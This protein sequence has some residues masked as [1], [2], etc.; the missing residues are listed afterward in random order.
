[1]FEQG[2]TKHCRLAMARNRHRGALA[3]SLVAWH[4]AVTSSPWPGQGTAPLGVVVSAQTCEVTVETDLGLLVRDAHA[5]SLASIAMHHPHTYPSTC[6]H[7]Y[8]LIVSALVIKL[9][10]CV[11]TTVA[12]RCTSGTCLPVV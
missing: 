10:M 8:G 11:T 1:V 7:V 3:L 9:P 6:T 5:T 2:R 12:A 4:A